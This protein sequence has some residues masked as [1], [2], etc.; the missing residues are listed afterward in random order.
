MMRASSTASPWRSRTA[1]STD[2]RRALMSDFCVSSHE[3]IDPKSNLVVVAKSTR[4]RSC[5]L[6][7]PPRPRGGG[8][9]AEAAGGQL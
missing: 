9:G 8:Q 1:G 6:R 7:S 3:S 4:T 5:V 2:L